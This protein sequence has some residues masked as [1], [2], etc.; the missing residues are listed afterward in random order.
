MAKVPITV[1]IPSVFEVWSTYVIFGKLCEMIMVSI[2]L[3]L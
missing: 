2:H 1:Q 3:Y